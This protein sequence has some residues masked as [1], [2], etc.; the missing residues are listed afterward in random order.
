MCTSM[1]SYLIHL[2]WAL[3]LIL[4]M[5][6]PELPLLSCSV[7]LLLKNRKGKLFPSLSDHIW[8]LPYPAQIYC[9][10]VS[11][12]FVFAEELGSSSFWQARAPGSQK[13]ISASLQ[14]EFR[15]LPEPFY[16]FPPQLD[17]EE[18]IYQKPSELRRGQW[19]IHSA[20]TITSKTDVTWRKI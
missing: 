2:Q 3:N 10:E 9:I 16:Q 14:L 12:L 11:L 13:L 6:M 20:I 4:H 1:I 19:E 17:R 5:D 15:C 8:G 18:E 7:S